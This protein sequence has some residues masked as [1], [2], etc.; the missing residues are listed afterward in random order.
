[1]LLIRG[2]KKK[3]E[4]KQASNNN[5]KKFFISILKEQAIFRGICLQTATRREK[6]H[7]PDPLT[8]RLMS[9][10]NSVQAVLTSRIA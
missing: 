5:N 3:N 10:R 8:S 4:K 2:K 7:R 1:L 9:P 6:Q